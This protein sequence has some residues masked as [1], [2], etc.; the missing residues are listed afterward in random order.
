MEDRIGPQNK[1]AKK[2]PMVCTDKKKV[3]RAAR[4]TG[5]SQ[6]L[7]LSR[8]S[9]GYVRPTKDEIAYCRKKNIT[10]FQGRLRSLYKLML[11]QRLEEEA[12][13]RD[14]IGTGYNVVRSGLHFKELML[15]N[16]SISET[17]F[18]E[19]ASR[20]GVN[21]LY[22]LSRYGD[23]FE[24]HNPG[25]SI[26]TCIDTFNRELVYDAESESYEVIEPQE[27]TGKLVALVIRE[28][29]S[30]CSGK[31]VYQRFCSVLRMLR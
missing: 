18:S 26:V 8:K 27:K 4:K 7:F 15:R 19:W 29:L 6:E 1:S 11:E 25:H 13:R 30:D 24:I 22:H 28:G 12:L 9:K 21:H 2:K 3:K 14:L 20:I 5:M 16:S 23:E 31:D 10:V 17:V